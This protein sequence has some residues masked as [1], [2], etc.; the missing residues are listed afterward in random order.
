MDKEAAGSGQSP[1]RSLIE[2][3][4]TIPGVSALGAATILA[5]TGG[6]MSRFPTAGH[7]IAWAGLCATWHRVISAYR[8]RRARA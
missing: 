6:D 4:S 8:M 7:L 1:F 2:L 3:L 5:E